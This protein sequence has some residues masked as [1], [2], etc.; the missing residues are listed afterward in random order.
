MNSGEII[1]II[2]MVLIY[3]GA[4]VSFWVRLNVKLKELELMIQ[5]NNKL[6]NDHVEWDNKENERHVENISNLRNDNKGEHKEMMKS[7]TLILEKLTDFQ[8]E[9]VGKSK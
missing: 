5:N 1:A 4:L 9:M 8:I 7:M 2:G 6:F 3:S